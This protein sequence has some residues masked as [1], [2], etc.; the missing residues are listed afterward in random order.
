MDSTM[1]FPAGT[2]IT[3]TEPVTVDQLVALRRQIVEGG[4]AA[5]ADDRQI[6]QAGE[7][8]PVYVTREYRLALSA[9]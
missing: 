7:G 3:V 9:D 4:P 6:Q 5:V 1:E 8:I 2:V